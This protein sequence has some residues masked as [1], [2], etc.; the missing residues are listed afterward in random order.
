[1]SY[2]TLSGAR[3]SVQVAVIN[4]S[5]PLN[6]SGNVVQRKRGQHFLPERITNET[7]SL[8]I[9]CRDQ[10]EKN[11]VTQF[12]QDHQITA[13]SSGTSEISIVWPEEEMFF[14]GIVTNSEENHVVG[15]VAPLISLSVVLVDDLLSTKTT[16][17]S[18]AGIFEQFYLSAQNLGTFEPPLTG[19]GSLIGGVTK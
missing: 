17:T 5:F 2:A 13:L 3:G 6:V 8:T 16:E 11:L 14:T 9:R 18:S 4:Y 12:V 1:M 15:E 7:M 10:Q 19:G